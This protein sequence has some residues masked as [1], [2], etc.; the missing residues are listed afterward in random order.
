MEESFSVVGETARM[1][2]S[3]AMPR[4]ARVEIRDPDGNLLHS[5]PAQISG[6]SV[7]AELPAFPAG[8]LGTIQ[9]C[10]DESPEEAT[11][12]LGLEELPTEPVIMVVQMG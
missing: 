9:L 7:S 8:T 4:S 5:I 6:G 3:G 10:T 12:A 1:D 11:E 2:M